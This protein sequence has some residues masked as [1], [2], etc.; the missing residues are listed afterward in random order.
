MDIYDDDLLQVWRKLAEHGVRYIMI[1]GI[2]TNLY[3]YNRYTKDADFYFEDTPENRERIA[4]AFYELNIMPR[5]VML[6]WQFVPGW[7][8]IEYG[9]GVVLDMMTDVKGL[10]D[11]SFEQCYSMA[12]FADVYD[13]RVPILHLNHLLRS[14]EA[15]N[16]PKDQLD[17]IELK[18]LE[19]L[20]NGKA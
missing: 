6:R 4:D 7:A 14:K 2:A 3:G 15:A 11:L 16:R 17:I 18:R 19:D 20:R 9:K 8:V 12:T 5:D 1:G 13:L 10:E